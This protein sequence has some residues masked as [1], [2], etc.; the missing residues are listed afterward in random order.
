[1]RLRKLIVA[2]LLVSS[3]AYADEFDGK[4]T[5]TLDQKAKIQADQD[6]AR[7]KIDEKYKDDDSS[8]A[9]AA[10]QREYE[11]AE[12]AALK[13]NGVGDK[14][15]LW[16]TSH[17]A[18]DARQAID[19]KAKA[20]EA[21]RKADAEAAKNKPAAGPEVVRGFDAAHPLDVTPGS[22]KPQL[23]ANGNPIPK[24]EKLDEDPAAGLPPL[25]PE[26]HR[27]SR[28]RHHR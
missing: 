14:D 10:K 21:K 5:L 11:A 13:K 1:M 12:H 28:R 26:H 23:D 19:E 22:E 3:L 17:D 18:P 25:P 20:I 27:G 16:Q 6:E 15:Y 24:V 8:D 4:P 7:K 9:R 2:S